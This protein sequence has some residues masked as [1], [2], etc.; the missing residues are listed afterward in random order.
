M[1]RLF[2]TILLL[3]MLPSLATKWEAPLH[4]QF[5]EQ[6]ELIVIYDAEKDA[7]FAESCLPQLRE[8]AID[9]QLRLVERQPTEGVPSEL[10]TTP[11]IVYQNHRGRSVYAAR[12]ASFSSIVNFVRT[13]RFVPQKAADNCKEEV[14][15]WKKGRAQIVAPIKI[16]PL[17]GSPPKDFDQQ[18]FHRQALKAIQDSL[19]QFEQL[20]KVCLQR[21][22]RAFY[23]DFHPYQDAEGRF[24]L[25]Y[26][27]YS[28][29][30]CI[31]PVFASGIQPL[32][33]SFDQAFQLFGQAGRQLEQEVARQLRESIIGDAVS[34]IAS[35]VPQGE[36]AALNLDLPAAPTSALVDDAIV[37]L[38]AKWEYAGA[39]DEDTPALQFHFQAPLD[40]YAGE[41]RELGGQMQ[42]DEGAGSL[43]GRFEVATKSLTMGMMDLDA[44]V[45]KKYIK[46]F[47]YPTSSFE[48]DLQ[49][50]LPDMKVGQTTNRSI[51]G[52]FE[53][54]KKR[55]PIMVDASFSP[56]L[57]EEGQPLMLVQA[58]F[59]MN[60]TDDFG[61]DG[62]DGPA[63]A[64]KTVMCNL[65]FYMKPAS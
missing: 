8:Y 26:E 64:N 13:A 23:L 6:Q 44:K 53:L 30:S 25:S 58:G 9:K 57:D 12:Y 62:P 32:S 21:T 3:G 11:A 19:L 45:L 46:A 36:W 24:F 54:M 7:F 27:L 14:L 10:T 40:R 61:I 5:S 18:G 41:V 51:P 65:V 47:R 33:G 2:A 35:D 39:V 15:C 43:Q 1:Y 29:F 28:Q 60:I 52:T 48:F 31:D 34:P 56:L 22:D 17:T 38:P 4:H 50:D 59:S 49:S 42:L 20:A 37:S 55:K 16:T 63:P